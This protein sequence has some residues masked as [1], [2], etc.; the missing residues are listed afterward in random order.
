M[1][2]RCA[3]CSILWRGNLISLSWKVIVIYLS[4]RVSV[5]FD[6]LFCCSVIGLNKINKIKEVTHSD[7]AVTAK[8]TSTPLMFYLV[9]DLSG[10]GSTLTGS[11]A[12]LR[13]S[14]YHS[15]S[16]IPRFLREGECEAHLERNWLTLIFIDYCYFQF[17]TRY[18]F[19][20]SFKISHEG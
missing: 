4:P 13:K 7:Q 20:L 3:V 16:G 2:I 17:R 15:S 8:L 5:F 9:P 18:S 12:S 10:R 6:S 19:L 1:H 11:T 14:M